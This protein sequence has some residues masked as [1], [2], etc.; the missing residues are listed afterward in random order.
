LTLDD[1]P[2]PPPKRIKIKILVLRFK[3]AVIFGQKHSR[4]DLNMV[5]NVI[6]YPQKQLGKLHLHVSSSKVLR[7]DD[8]SFTLRVSMANFFFQNPSFHDRLFFF[9]R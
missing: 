5:E 9:A 1:D 3:K 7:D 2:L 8:M 6:Y 4:S